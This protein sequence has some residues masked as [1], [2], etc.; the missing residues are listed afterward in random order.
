M[1]LG[2]LNLYISQKTGISLAKL[3]FKVALYVNCGDANTLVWQSYELRTDA[4]DLPI[5]NDGPTVRFLDRF[6]I[7]VDKADK[8]FIARNLCPAALWCFPG[9]WRLGDDYKP[10]TAGDAPEVDFSKKNFATKVKRVIA[11]PSWTICIINLGL[12]LAGFICLG[13]RIPACVSPSVTFGDFNYD[14]AFSASVCEISTTPLVSGI[15]PLLAIE[16][17]DCYEYITMHCYEPPVIGRLCEDTV[18]PEWF[19]RSSLVLLKSI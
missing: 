5:D 17:D 16:D 4:E 1:R 9:T 8:R 13:F 3:R 18:V 2:R 12:L 15:P 6:L 10:L 11:W 7:Y 19:T 14:S